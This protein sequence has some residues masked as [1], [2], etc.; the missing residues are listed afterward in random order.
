MNILINFI[1]IALVNSFS[2]LFLFSFQRFQFESPTK[3]ANAG[4][5]YKD[6]INLKSGGINIINSIVRLYAFF[7]GSTSKAIGTL[8]R[9][10]QLSDRCGLVQSDRDNLKDIWLLLQRMRWRHQLQQ[11]IYNNS[12]RLSDLSSFEQHQLKTAF[13]TIQQNQAALMMKFSPGGS[14]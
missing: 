14:L 5:N 12:I 1:F 11:G 10:Q 3:H 6:G 4:H 7:E 9:L 8:E 2:S 13:K